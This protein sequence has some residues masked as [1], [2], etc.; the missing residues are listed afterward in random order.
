MLIV[1]LILTSCTGCR[2]ASTLDESPGPDDH[3]GMEQRLEVL[4]RVTLHEHGVRWHAGGEAMR[5]TEIVEGGRGDGTERR[6]L[7]QTQFVETDR[8]LGDLAVGNG[9]VGAGEYGDT[10]TLGLREQL[11]HVV[12]PPGQESSA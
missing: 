3:S 1:V 9:E 2:G 12:D 7:R 10:E 5:H 11:P 4:L 8:F 6:L